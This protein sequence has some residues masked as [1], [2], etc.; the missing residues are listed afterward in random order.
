VVDAIAAGDEAA[1]TQ[2]VGAMMETLRT[3]YQAAQE[4]RAARD[5]ATDVRSDGVD[6][7]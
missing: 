2:A 1:A 5:A 6:A 3:Q 4:W 7:V